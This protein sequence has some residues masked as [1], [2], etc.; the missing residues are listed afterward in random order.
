MVPLQSKSGINTLSPIRCRVPWILRIVLS[1]LLVMQYRHLLCSRYL[2]SFFGKSCYN[3]IQSIGLLVSCLDDVS[4]LN[5]LCY[6]LYRRVEFWLESKTPLLF[7]LELMYFFVRNTVCP[8]VRFIFSGIYLCTM[9]V[10][11]SYVLRIIFVCSS[12]YLR[13]LYWVAFSRDSG[14]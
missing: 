8:Y 5:R 7:W 1:S 6:L 4:C 9:Y 11:S 13:R 14:K 2:A 12:C 10:I 3:N